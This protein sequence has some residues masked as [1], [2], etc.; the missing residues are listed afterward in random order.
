MAKYRIYDCE[1]TERITKLVEALYNKRPE[2]ES[3]RAV[4]LTES[5]KKTESEPT[6][7]RRNS[8]IMSV[9]SW[10]ERAGMTF[11]SF[12][13]LPQTLTR[14]TISTRETREKASI[15]S[16]RESTLSVYS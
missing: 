11:P 6:I 4:L 12:S 9:G 15:F 1:K 16:V 3:A 2:I 10:S 7:M 8:I 14:I 5:Y 13:A